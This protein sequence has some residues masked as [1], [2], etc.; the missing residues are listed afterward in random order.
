MGIS[1]QAWKNCTKKYP[2]IFWERNFYPDILTVAND[3]L[4]KGLL[5]AGEY[6]IKIDW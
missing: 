3:L 1:F 2:D 4:A 6:R 5:E